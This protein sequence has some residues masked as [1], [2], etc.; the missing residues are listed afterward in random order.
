MESPTVYYCKNKECDFT[1]FKEDKNLSSLKVKVT[2]GND[3][4]QTSFSGTAK[5]DSGYSY[6]NSSLQG[7]VLN[8]NSLPV[9]NYPLDSLVIKKV[10]ST[11]GN[12]LEG[13]VFEVVQVSEGISGSNGTTIGRYTN[14]ESGIIVITV[15]EAGHYL[16]REVQ[17][18]QNYTLQENSTQNAYMKV[19]DTSIVELTFT[20]DLNC[21]S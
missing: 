17:T 4:G 5:A 2:G 9:I 7:T 16:V 18:Q 13:A 21:E 10:D 20:N 19:N 1:I 11:N 3:N 8:N 6:L 14:D 12:L 15:L